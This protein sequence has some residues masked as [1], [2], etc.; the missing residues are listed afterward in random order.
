M[1]SDPHV[2]AVVYSAAKVVDDVRDG[3]LDGE[4]GLCLVR[5]ML[6]ASLLEEGDLDHMTSL[7]MDDASSPEECIV[8]ALAAVLRRMALQE[9]SA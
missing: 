3:L 6:V 9:V 4:S 7:L 2:A 8:V 1:R 5:D